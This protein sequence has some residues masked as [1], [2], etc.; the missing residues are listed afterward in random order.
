MGMMELRK[1]RGE[2]NP[3]DLFTKHLSSR[4]RVT[5]LTELFGC[6]FREGRADSA[7]SLRKET[8]EVN[9]VGAGKDRRGGRREPS[10]QEEPEQ[11]SEE[12][13]RLD[14]LPV[15]DDHVLP[16]EYAAEDLDEHFPRAAVRPEMNPEYSEDELLRLML[17]VRTAA[18]ETNAGHHRD[19]ERRE[20]G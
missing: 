1:V 3:A 15:H 18:L 16:H 2:V 4:E 6:H 11:K 8:V 5:K 20:P 14:S 17:Y 19:A 9:T 7:P 12:E 10:K 13:L